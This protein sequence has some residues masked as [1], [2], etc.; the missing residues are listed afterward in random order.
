MYSIDDFI[1]QFRKETAI[2][3]RLF[4]NMP[5]GGLDYRPSPGQRSTLQL[6]R[7][8]SFG[9]GNGTRKILANDW[10]AGKP[11]AELSKDVPP[12]DFPRNMLRQAEEVE[13]LIRIADPV[14]IRNVNHVL[15][16]G[17]VTKQA[18]ALVNYPLNWLMSY[19]MQFFLYLKAAGAYTLATPDLWH[20]KADN[21]AE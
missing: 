3:I 19:R 11:T 17:E 15:P 7:Y 20:I 8:L 18:E 10:K 13:C 5:P 14:A 9:P 1:R 16:W 4:R 21:E 6:M 2:C 12:S